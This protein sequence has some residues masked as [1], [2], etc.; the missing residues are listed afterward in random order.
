[1]RR[2]PAQRAR[3]W[4]GCWLDDEEAEEFYRLVQIDDLTGAL[5]LGDDEAAPDLLGAMTELIGIDRTL[6]LVGWA[7]TNRDSFASTE[8]WDVVWEWA[9]TTKAGTPRKRR[10]HVMLD[11]EREAFADLPE[12]ITV[13]RGYA[14]DDK[15][16]KRSWTRD[17][18][19]AACFAHRVRGAD[20]VPRV[21]TLTISKAHVLA[22]LERHRNGE[23]EIV[24]DRWAL[25]ER[26]ADEITIAPAGPRPAMWEEFFHDHA[27]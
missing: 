27:A 4:F 23:E 22:L 1:M 26:Y 24:V 21:A 16:M 25:H 7:W 15:L 6:P 9:T 2:T 10:H 3:D 20:A 18:E 19:L 13:Y 12:E 14:T 17:P 5:T 8:H 11:H